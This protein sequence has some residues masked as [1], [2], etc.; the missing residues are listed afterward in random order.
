[1]LPNRLLNSSI[2]RGP[3]A[4]LCRVA[5]TQYVFARLELF[6]V[7]R[8]LVL[9]KARNVPQPLKDAVATPDTF[10]AFT[11]RL[12]WD[13]QSL[14]PQWAALAARVGDVV[15]AL[16]ALQSAA[17]APRKRDCPPGSSFNVS[18]PAPCKRNHSLGAAPPSRSPA[19]TAGVDPP[20]SAAIAATSSAD[21]APPLF[22]PA[23]GS[24]SLLV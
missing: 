19:D 15:P 3:D 10:R 4:L 7:R 17:G 14:P 21:G 13:A 1:M 11:L 5:G 23:V 24:A 22:A 18:A 2:G 9:T 6:T 20:P 8:L 12:G 16:E